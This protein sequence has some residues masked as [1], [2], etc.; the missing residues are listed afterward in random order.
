MFGYIECAKDELRV[1]EL[2]QYRSYYCGV[3]HS[4]RSI[5]AFGGLVL[6]NDAVFYALLTDIFEKSEHMESKCFIKPQ[7]HLCAMGEHIDRAALINIIL[8]I[9]L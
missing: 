5:S 6:A 4:L 3:C 2:V 9:T 1:K 7:K 8:F